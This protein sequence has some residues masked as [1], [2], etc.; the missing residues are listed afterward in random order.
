MIDKAGDGAL[1]W[2]FTALLS[3]LVLA[4]VTSRESVGQIAWD[5][6]AVILQNTN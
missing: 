5:V 4:A 6:I 1:I 3:G 2:T